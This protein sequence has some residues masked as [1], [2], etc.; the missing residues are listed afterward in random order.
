MPVSLMN[1]ANQEIRGATFLARHCIIAVRLTLQ[2]RCLGC[3]PRKKKG[4]LERRRR[5]TGDEARCFSPGLV[6]LEVQMKIHLSRAVTRNRL[7][8]QSVVRQRK[9]VRRAAADQGSG[10]DPTIRLSRLNQPCIHQQNP[11]AK[12][13]ADAQPTVARRETAFDQRRPD[14]DRE[15]QY[16]QGSLGQ[17]G[18][19]R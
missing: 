13:S 11:I 16:Q 6:K 9:F 2:C 19:W 4:S 15:A 12:H 7:G 10:S 1:C 17:G 3:C 5:P 8:S 18:F 14:D